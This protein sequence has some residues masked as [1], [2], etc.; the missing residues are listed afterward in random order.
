MPRWTRRAALLGALALAGTA[1]TLSLASASTSVQVEQ[2]LQVY[3]Q[4]CAECH[5]R[6]LEGGWGPAL[7]GSAFRRKW[8]SPD[9]LRA[10]L[11][12]NMPFA[13]AGTL[14]LE[15][16]VN[17]TAF[18]LDHNGVPADGFADPAIRE[19]WTIADQPV[20]GGAARRSWLWGP[21]G[22]ATLWE[23]YA[24]APGGKR[25]VQYFDKAR[26]EIT[27]L[28]APRESVDYVSY[29]LLARDLVTGQVQIGKGQFKPLRPAEIAVAGDETDRLGP[30]Y[31]TFA[32]LTGRVEP[33]Q[34]PVT[35]TIDRAGTVGAAPALGEYAATVFYVQET[36]HNIPNVF[37]DYLNSRGLLNRGGQLAEGPLFDPWYAAVGL[38]ITEPY[39]AKVTV[40]GQVRDVLVQVFERRA[41]T[42]TPDNPPGFQV[43]MGNVGQHYFRWRYGQ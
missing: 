30:T 41:L 27:Q 32:A 35:A 1:L 29:G 4:R 28:D 24:E 14:S 18:L 22:F 12:Q 43:E 11:Q 33:R 40:G 5:G 15:E 34:A 19:R 23:D 38:P 2:G 36:G 7:E 3:R 31:A 8:T 13:Q 9:K 17:V 10:Y 16:Y 20:A 6:E 39:W 25:L 26:M 37:W 42:Y 21:V